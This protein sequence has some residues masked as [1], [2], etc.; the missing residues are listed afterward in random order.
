PYNNTVNKD[1]GAGF[2]IRRIVL[3]RFFRD[4]RALL[5][6]DRGPFSSTEALMKIDLQIERIKNLSPSPTDEYFSEVDADLV[7]DQFEAL[8]T[9]YALKNL[10]AQ[11]FQL[12][13]PFDGVNLLRHSDIS[14]DNIIVDTVSHRISGIIDWGCVAVLPTW[15]TVA[16]P[17]FLRGIEFQEPPPLGVDEEGLIE[18]RKDWE[19]VLLPRKYSE[20]SYS[21]VLCGDKGTV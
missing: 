11:T 2:I 6:V 18:I 15:E 20:D 21:A 1:I 16:L 5:A 14:R 7:E 17:P 9:C 10:I 13:G 3:P 8:E 4:K 12:S 19:L